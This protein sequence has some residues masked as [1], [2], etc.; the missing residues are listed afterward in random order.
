MRNQAFQFWRKAIVLTLLLV[1]SVAAFAQSTSIPDSNFE[2][3]LV[4]LGIDS[5]GIVN[6]QV[7]TSNIENVISLNLRYKNI[8]DLTGIEDFIS[9]EDLNVFGNHLSTLSMTNN[10]A[11]MTLDASVNPLNSI[12]LSNNILLVNY[13]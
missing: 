12:D 11:L 3:A 8:S 7:L 4:D 9:L 5:D 10:T 13:V 6:G 2:Q 1:F